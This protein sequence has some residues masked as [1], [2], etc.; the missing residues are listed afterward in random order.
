[1]SD[2]VEWHLSEKIQVPTVPWRLPSRS[3][4]RGGRSLRNETRDLLT[5]V[6]GVG[7]LL[8]HQ[9]DGTRR[10]K[11]KQ[12]T[13]RHVVYGLGVPLH[14]PARRHKTVQPVS[15]TDLSYGP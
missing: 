8:L 11:L 2:T 13:C 6:Y 7:V 12:R 4:N 10:F 14:W 1:M 15:E 9:L 5:V 3:L